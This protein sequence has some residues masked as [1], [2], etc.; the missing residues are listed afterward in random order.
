MALT[1]AGDA[2]VW[3]CNRCRAA[4]AD[5]LLLAAD[6]QVYHDRTAGGCGQPV[7]LTALP[8][9]PDALLLGCAC[10]SSCHLCGHGPQPLTHPAVREKLPPVPLPATGDDQP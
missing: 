1:A 8:G 2:W 6:G 3:W 10:P 5:A 7:G 4:I 9:T